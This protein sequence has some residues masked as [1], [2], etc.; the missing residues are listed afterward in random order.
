MKPGEDGGG[1]GEEDDGRVVVTWVVSKTVPWRPGVT[2]ERQH[3]QRSSGGMTGGR[4]AHDGESSGRVVESGRL[5]GLPRRRQGGPRTQ[6]M[7]GPHRRPPRWAPMR[8]EQWDTR[9]V[10][11]AADGGSGGLGVG[12]Q[13]GLAIEWGCVENFR[14]GLG[15]AGTWMQKRCSCHLDCQGR[16][17]AVYIG[18]TGWGWVCHAD[19]KSLLWS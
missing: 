1:D 18:P 2:K 10:H 12:D 8:G 11:P 15:C 5:A 16:A 3:T 4:S 14:V 6:R 7:A 13:R 9:V 19:F 17:P